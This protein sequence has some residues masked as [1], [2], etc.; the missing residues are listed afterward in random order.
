MQACYEYDIQCC[1]IFVKT[2]DEKVI[3]IDMQSQIDK[4]RVI[5]AG[6][7]RE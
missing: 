5:P 3:Q 2:I 6:V 1:L 7:M 4:S